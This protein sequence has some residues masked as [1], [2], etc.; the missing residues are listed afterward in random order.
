MVWTNID[1]CPSVHVLLSAT[2]LRN[3]SKDNSLHSHKCPAG[4]HIKFLLF[5]FDL[6][7]SWNFSLYFRNILEYFSGKSFGGG[8][9]FMLT[10]GQTAWGGCRTLS[11][12]L[13]QPPLYL[14][15]GAGHFGKICFFKWATANWTQ[16]TE[17]L[18][19]CV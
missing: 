12:T 1:C 2:I 14:L 18:Q 11:G 7:Q 19:L 9:R 3:C 4:P 15:C 8:S 5:W 10:D 13:R 16:I 17:V 6:N